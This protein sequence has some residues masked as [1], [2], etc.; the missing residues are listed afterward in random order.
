[1]LERVLFWGGEGGLKRGG[2][3]GKGGERG[4]EEGGKTNQVLIFGPG[5]DGDFEFLGGYVDETLGWI[6][7]LGLAILGVSLTR[8]RIGV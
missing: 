3:G 7:G 1:M 2:R 8:M 6:R 5:A 4:G